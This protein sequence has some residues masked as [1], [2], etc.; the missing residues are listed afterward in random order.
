MRI[1]AAGQVASEWLLLCG[2]AAVGLGVTL[3]HLR[4]AGWRPVLLSFI[5][6]LLAGTSALIWCAFLVMR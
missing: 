6:A 1:L 2:M 4:E 3:S 5:A